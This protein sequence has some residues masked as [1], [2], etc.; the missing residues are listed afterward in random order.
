MLRS[1]PRYS[2]PRL[3][4]LDESD[5][6]IINLLVADGRASGRDLAQ[7]TGLSEANV[8]R[9]L[10]RLLQERSVRIVAFV[11][12][13][14]LGLPMQFITM[15]RTRGDVDAV[16]A[17]LLAHPEFAYITGAFGPWDLMVYGVLSDSHALMALHDRAL[18]GNRLVRDAHTEVVL[19]F[20]DPSRREGAASACRALDDTDRL[21]IRQVQA[22]GRMSFTDIAQAT[23]ISATSAADRFRRLVADGIVRIVTLPDPG[24]VGLHVSGHVA[25]SVSVPVSVAVER[26]AAFPELSF[27]CALTGSHPIR[28]EFQVKDAAAFDALRTRLL[29]IDGVRDLVPSVHRRLYRQSFVWG[30]GRET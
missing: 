27:L 14:C 21:V 19:G 5:R 11:P 2:D 8:S 28:A 26:L 9:R 24:R 17:D 16:A 15:I 13:E 25:M 30:A 3:P 1:P 10:A 18:A 29:S 7:Q 6:Q 22:D 23:G 20:P 4:P 12:P